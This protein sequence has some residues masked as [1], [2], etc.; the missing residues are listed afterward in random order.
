MTPAEARAKLIE[1]DREE[2]TAR[3]MRTAPAAV[4]DER[5]ASAAWVKTQLARRSRHYQLLAI[6]TGKVTEEQA[7]RMTTA[8]LERVVAGARTIPA[9]RRAVPSARI[10]VVSPPVVHMPAPDWTPRPRGDA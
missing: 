7:L 9:T 1:L 3:A 5:A 2:F 6:A 8:E 4:L 10:R